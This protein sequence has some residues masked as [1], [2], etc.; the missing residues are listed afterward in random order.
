MQQLTEV[1]QKMQEKKITITVVKLIKS[2]QDGAVVETLRKLMPTR[3]FV[4]D[5]CQDDQSIQTFPAQN[6]LSITLQN[7]FGQKLSEMIKS[8]INATIR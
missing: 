2:E 7:A 5:L 6:E 4:E 3:F 1:A 8:R